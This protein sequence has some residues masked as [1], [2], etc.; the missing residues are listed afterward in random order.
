MKIGIDARFYSSAFTGIGRYI[1]ELIDH[2]LKKDGENEYVLFFNEPGF[3]A[4]QPPRKG[5]LKVFAGMRHYSFEEQ[6]RYARVI[7]E[8]CVDLMHFTH[9]NA[10]VLYRGPSVVTIHDL[11]L[12][13]YPGKKMARSWHRFAYHLVIRSVVRRSKRII[14]VSEHTKRDV[15][16]FLRA[17]PGKI[18]VIHEGVNHAFHRLQDERLVEEFLG[19]I[20][21]ASPYLLYTGVWRSHKNLVNLIKAFAILKKKHRFPG[22]LVITGK[23]DPWY[24][25]VQQA[26]REENLEG[27]VRFT[28]LVPD[29]DLVLLYNGAS[30]FACGVPVCAARSS[31]LP[32]ICGEE[33]A[34]FFDPHSPEDMAVKIASVYHDPRRAQELIT[35]GYQRVKDFSWEKMALQ[36]LEV[37][38][39]SL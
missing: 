22:L 14:A 23:E 12:N 7:R 10:P 18:R 32:E 33:N 31:C 39:E 3:S 30:A 9:F 26:V 35:R 1:F 34:V 17:D 2:L 16:R 38:K 8:Q 25:E 13:M 19:R 5:V 21:L 20:A 29:E 4:Y 24:P 11:T 36:T 28:G 6:W 37:Y 15:I 27:Q